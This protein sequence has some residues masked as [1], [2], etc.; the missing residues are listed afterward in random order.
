M[1]TVPAIASITPRVQKLLSCLITLA[2]VTAL[3]SLCSKEVTRL[4]ED[5]VA[6]F[7]L[8]EAG[9]ALDDFLTRHLSIRSQPI[10][11]PELARPD[12]TGG[13]TKSGEVNRRTLASIECR[14][15][16]TADLLAKEL[17]S[18]LSCNLVE[19]IAH[20]V[21][22]VR[23]VIPASA[24]GAVLGHLGPSS[25][26][27]GCIARAILGPRHAPFPA[28]F[29]PFYCIERQSEPTFG[30]SNGETAAHLWCLSLHEL[31]AGQLCALCLI[32]YDGLPLAFYRDM[33]K[34]FYDETRHASFFLEAATALMP[35]IER[36][37]SPKAAH[38]RTAVKRYKALG[39]GLPVPLEGNLF[40]TFWNSD[41]IERLVLMHLDTE[42]PGVAVIRRHGAA[43]VWMQ[44]PDIRRGFEVV[45]AD[46]KTHAKIG[47][48]WIKYLLPDRDERLRAIDDARL[49][50]GMLIAT[51]IAHKRDEP[52]AAVIRRLLHAQ[53]RQGLDR[54]Y[55]RHASQ[56][57]RET[58]AA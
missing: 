33:A 45:A 7:R 19:P 58:K 49:L 32:E 53:P 15:H 16:A 44:H 41:L 28:T 1:R 8:M 39:V 6:T 50:R 26:R 5:A 11:W 54:P 20:A 34:Q 18:A 51:S 55:N 46:E 43:R 52:V 57:F 4:Q 25:S 29:E 36:T 42:T 2:R 27:K 38:L 3:R 56:P 14:L 24:A 47:S 48:N 22:A 35:Y 10:W 17:L 12:S 9:A 30:R 21:A 23:S 31:T 13:L 37:K 40:E